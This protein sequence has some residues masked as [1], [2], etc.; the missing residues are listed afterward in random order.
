[1]IKEKDVL[2]KE[3]LKSLDH[4]K[5]EPWFRANYHLLPENSFYTSIALEAEWYES[6]LYMMVAKALFSSKNTNDG[7]V[8]AAHAVFPSYFKAKN[9]GLDKRTPLNWSQV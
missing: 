5:Q 2:K 6:H 4:G 3:F 1:M 7:V 8:D 9:L